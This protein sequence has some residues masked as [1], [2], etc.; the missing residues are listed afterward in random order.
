[1]ALSAADVPLSLN[2]RDF[3]AKGDGVTD[4]SAAIQATV[5]E[6]AKY[7]AAYPRMWGA[8]Y[9]EIVFPEGNY[10]ISRT[11]V[12]ATGLIPDGG[13]KSGRATN[14]AFSKGM[15]F[16]YIR[17]EGKASIRQTNAERD[18]FY[19]GMAYKI[20]I[21]NLSF[22]GGR[23]SINMWTGNQD[24]SMP[25]IRNCKFYDSSDYAI[26]TPYITRNSAGDFF[27]YSITKEDGTMEEIR[28]PSAKHFLYHSTYLHIADC[29]FVNCMK[30]LFTVADMGL[31]ENSSIITN[32]AMKGAA[33][34]SA[35]LLKLYNIK[36]IAKVTPGN[37]QRW[38]DLDFG[39][40]DWIIGEKLDLSTDSEQGLC[41]VY[42]MDKFRRSGS[43]NPGA[44]VL[45]NSK[46]KVSGAS[47]NALIYCKEVTNLINVSDCEETGKTPVPVIGLASA[48]PKGYFAGDVPGKAPIVPNGLAYCIDSNNKNFTT[49][50][51]ELMKPYRRAA[52]PQKEDKR[53]AEL[54]KPDLD[55]V[56][57]VKNFPAPSKKIRVEAASLAGDGVT[58]D[59]EAL[60]KI[61]DSVSS[62]GITELVLPGA[63]YFFD[64]IIKLPPNLI[65][66]ASGRAVFMS[67][68][69][70]KAGFQA[71]NVENLAF[72]NCSFESG[73]RQFDISLKKG[74][75]S[76]ILFDNCSFSNS[77]DIAI[78]CRSPET[79]YSERIKSRIRITSSVFYNNQRALS[80]NI[81]GIM[82]SCWLAGYGS[83]FKEGVNLK[84]KRSWEG[85]N[86]RK[87]LPESDPVRDLV[88]IRNDGFMRAENILGV[89]MG[90]GYGR[91]FRW[92]DNSGVLV[93]EYFRFGGEQGGRCGVRI[94]KPEQSQPSITVIQNSWTHHMT[95]AHHYPDNPEAMVP[96]SHIVR[97]EFLPELLVLRNNIGMETSYLPHG[98][99]GATV[100]SPDKSILAGLDKSLFMSCNLIPEDK[101]LRKTVEEIKVLAVPTQ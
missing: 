29:E 21:E 33:I 17:G 18:I 76:K 27:G 7:T 68:D 42:C 35:G 39:A 5:N 37:E 50:L 70:S 90:K 47:E 72:L 88:D 10:L 79:S 69:Q 48:L 61:F 63:V 66:R 101:A 94:I 11:I 67:P 58:D 36:G 14:T 78:V 45:K 22:Y 44:I 97:C 28:D 16:A 19:V 71:E 74:Y 23:H 56:L 65:V 93:C 55:E 38:I 43:Y 95:G 86:Y 91:D 98:V 80:S 51:P 49:D 96:Q 100:Q 75:V 9:P 12:I 41:V 52:L 30:V 83:T 8:A 92:F 46:F 40:T 1:M 64:R 13:L 99:I 31:M 3:G 54:L 4:D 73:L 32:P 26:Q 20:L 87:G 24:V 81:Y 34:R 84:S 57:S 85:A 89:P 25:I 2:V 82:D 59:G 53:I 6:A 77:S 60:Q 62:E 15:G